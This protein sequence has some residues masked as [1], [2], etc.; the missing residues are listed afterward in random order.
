MSRLPFELS[1]P[2]PCT[3]QWS[4]MPGSATIRHCASCNTP[5]HNFAALTQRQI[6]RLILE[7]EGHF[8]ARMISKADGELVTAATNHPSLLSAFVL[9]STLSSSAAL[10]QGAAKQTAVVTGTVLTP[11]N[12]KYIPPNSRREVMFVQAE[13]AVLSVSTD[14]SG[15]FSATIP[16]GTYDVVFRSGLLFGERVNNVTFHSGTQ[17]FSPV[18]ERFDYGHLSEVDQHNQTFVTMGEVISVPV[19]R[20]PVRNLLIHPVGVARTI[21]YRAKRLLHL[22]S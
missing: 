11:L 2:K 1:I 21:A 6:A 22:S 3:Q 5:V 16:T 20:V 19:H 7:S 9:A 13:K 4:E 14:S 17:E 12:S 15:K 10:A 18:Q 8:C